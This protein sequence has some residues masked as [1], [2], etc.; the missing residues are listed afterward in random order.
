FE[1]AGGRGRPGVPAPPALAAPHPITRD[2]RV[3]EVSLKDTIALALEN[4][5]GIAA[6]RLEPTRQAAGILD[7]QG[8]YDP[9]FAGELLHSHA[10]T[11]NTSSLA[12]T[13][14]AKVDDRSA[15]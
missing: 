6:R 8:Q 3:Q 12:G 5:P 11:P 13:K 14:T 9:T 10:V 2:D 15:N 7:A 4:N 1:A